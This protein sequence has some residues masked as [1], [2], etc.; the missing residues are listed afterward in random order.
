[1]SHKTPRDMD[2]PHT[3]EMPAMIGQDSRITPH[4][5]DAGTSDSYI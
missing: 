2:A 3:Q 5:V 4:G 1:M